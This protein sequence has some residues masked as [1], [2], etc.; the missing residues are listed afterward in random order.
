MEANGGGKTYIPVV[1]ERGGG[2]AGGH[3]IRVIGGTSIRHKPKRFVAAIEP[4]TITILAQINQPLIQSVNSS[5]DKLV[6]VPVLVRIDFF[7]FAF[8]RHRY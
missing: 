5:L 7:L 1:D 6:L 8:T 3:A 2:T 4:I